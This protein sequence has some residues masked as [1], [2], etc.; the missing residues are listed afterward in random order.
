ML[1]FAIDPNGER[2]TEARKGFMSWCCCVVPV[3]HLHDQ[4][5][6]RIMYGSRFACLGHG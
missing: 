5:A 1:G 4:I 2:R 3:E 6:A